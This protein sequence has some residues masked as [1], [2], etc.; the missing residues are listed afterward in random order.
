METLVATILAEMD[1]GPEDL[2][3]YVEPLVLEPEAA[4]V[5]RY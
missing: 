1:V 2:S 5:F 3:R 4:A